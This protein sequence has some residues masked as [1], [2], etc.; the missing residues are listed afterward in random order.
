MTARVRV[1]GRGDICLQSGR[2]VG[3]ECGGMIRRGERLLRGLLIAA[4]VGLGPL[5][6]DE[7]VPVLLPTPAS[8]SED[9]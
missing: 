7:Q 6:C 2:V 1:V 5:V 8:L 3:T 9:P 4:A